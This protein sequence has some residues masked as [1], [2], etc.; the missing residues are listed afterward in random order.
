MLLLK[1]WAQFAKT[2]PT[3]DIPELHIVGWRGWNNEDVFRFLDT[4]PLV[5]KHVFETSDLNDAD[6]A[7]KMGQ[8][9][10]LLFPS[11]AEGFGLPAL[12]AAQMGV[13][14]IC[15]DLPVFHE[16]L[17]DT[18]IFINALQ[19]QDWSETILTVAQKIKMGVDTGDLAPKLS[20]IPCWESHFCHV[21][22]DTET[23]QVFH[24]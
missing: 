5:G 8:S 18:A 13:P 12:E 22:G 20:A 21:F 11:H 14:V 24:E 9:A 3:E 16:I 2:L 4:S 15:S 1:V 19:T 6:L 7:K 23:Q 17:G 10:G